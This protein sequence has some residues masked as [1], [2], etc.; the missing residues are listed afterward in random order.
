MKK[1]TLQLAFW[2]SPKGMTGSKYWKRRMARFFRSYEKKADYWVD[3]LQT[4]CERQ[5]LYWALGGAITTEYKKARSI[6]R[7]QPCNGY[8]HFQQYKRLMGRGYRKQW[9]TL[10]RTYRR[11]LWKLQ[12]RYRRFSQRQRRRTWRSCRR[13]WGRKAN[14]KVAIY[15]AQIDKLPTAPAP[16]RPPAKRRAVALE[17]LTPTKPARR[18]ALYPSSVRSV[19]RRTPPPTRQTQPNTTQPRRPNT[20]RIAQTPPTQPLNTSGNTS[21]TKRLTPPTKPQQATP[22]TIGLGSRLF[23]RNFYY[24]DDIFGKLRPYQLPL[25]PALQIDF[26]WYPAAHFTNGWAS[27]IGIVGH[28][29][30]AVGLQS[31]TS[32]N[33]TL[34]TTAFG[35]HAGL[36][37]R[38]PIQTFSIRISGAY[39]QQAFS[40]SQGANTIIPDVQYQWVRPA[41]GFRWQIL[42]PL[43]LSG[44]FGY[45]FVF[46]AGQLS[47]LAFFPRMTIGGL[48]AR[49]AITWNFLPWLGARLG[50]Q[51]LHYFSDMHSQAG[52]PYIAGGSI[53][54]YFNADIGL[55]IQL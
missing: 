6:G 24:S 30:Y 3:K 12:R 2:Q 44:H 5:Q 22:L 31:Q 27:H 25:G 51:F 20:P 14:A 8:A 38:I 46:D 43:A 48:D 53:D 13:K 45:Q 55:V 50:A 28:V 39:G 41:L 1:L 18:V 33:S 9:R 49:L 47:S 37:V 42:A 34:D 54:Q 32:D 7:K 23:T 16:I 36:V 21:T 19:S 17:P 40:I 26:R 11:K 10:P 4:P 52:D 15:R 35:F 29:H